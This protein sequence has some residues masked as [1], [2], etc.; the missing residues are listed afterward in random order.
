MSVTRLNQRT[1]VDD[2]RIDLAGAIGSI[3]VAL[4]LFTRFSV[5]DPLL[6]DE[7]IYAYAGQQMAHGVPMYSSIFDPKA[8][9]AGMLA[10]LAAGIARLLSV[11]DLRT[12]RLAYLVV[13]V[14]TVL[15]MYLLGRQ[16]WRSP[17]AGLITATVFAA[18][19]GFAIDAVTGPN[20]KMPGVLC[21]V[22]A[23]Y[24]LARRQWFWAAFLGSVAGVVWQPFA[25]Y[26]ALAVLAAPV[27]AGQGRRLTAF[28]V[29]ALAS[30]IPVATVTGYFLATGTLG[31]LV[32][33]ALVFPAI[34]LQRG[35][36]SAPERLAHIA[37]VV[38][39]DYGFSGILFWV[40]ILALV[41]VLAVRL[42]RGRHELRRSMSDP[43][44]YAVLPTLLVFVG[45][46]ATDFQGYPD[47]Y[48]LLPYA[49]LGCGAVAAADLTW[50]RVERH[51]TAMTAGALAAVVLL[52]GGSAVLF[53]S[54]HADGDR[55][56]RQQRAD[57]CAIELLLGSDGTLYALGDPTPLVLTHRRNPDRFI[58]LGSGVGN[59][60]V[61]HTR[62]GAAGWYAQILA[63]HPSVIVLGGWNSAL[64]RRTEAWLSANYDA[65][66][67]GRWAVYLA[68][69]IR[70]RAERVRVRLPSR[71][72]TSAVTGDPLPGRCARS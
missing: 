8:P 59:W 21:A 2:R 54:E 61:A 33:A 56:G 19:Q 63:A 1:R 15:A 38:T 64:A 11:D 24:F 55:L 3:V 69:G 7:S 17:V 28:A 41:V 40:G 44:L 47:L 36:E 29:T 30:A 52:T 68:P 48:P 16:L 13:A 67:V 5:S 12:M 6:R 20:A 72:V 65:A 58:Y 22:V 66:Y 25:I 10:G 39:D 23:L 57:A 70:A 51:R 26:S 18:F 27:A 31:R 50:W 62:G 14:A 46:S 9:G 35:H 37:G 45:L 32:E 43:L 4:V 49:A 42:L 53:A 60:R 34:G 71:P